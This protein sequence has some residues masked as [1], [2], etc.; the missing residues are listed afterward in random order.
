MGKTANTT[1]NMDITGGKKLKDLFRGDQ[2]LHD[3]F[4]FKLHHQANFAVILIGVAF[5]FGQN[6]LN[7]N[8][9]E[10]KG[11]DVGD[12][13]KQYCWLHGAGHIDDTLNPQDI[14][15]KADQNEMTTEFK[16]DERQSHYYLWIPFVLVL[17]LAVI[18]APRVIWKE[19]CERG[20]IAGAVGGTDGKPAEKIAER[21]KK[22]RRRANKFHRAFFLCE[23]LNIASVIICFTILNTLFGGNFF[24]YGS[25]F[26]AYSGSGSEDTERETVNPMCNLFP[27]VVSCTLLTG[28][29]T[30]NADQTNITGGR[31]L[32]DLYRGDAVLHD[33]FLFKLHH[34]AN[35]AIVLL[36]VAFI[37][38]TNYLDG[39][40]IKC[41]GNN[42]GPFQEQYCWL[43]GSG[44]ITK[45]LNP[46]NIQCIA[47]QNQS[48]DDSDERH[49]RYYLWVPFILMLCLAIIKAPRVLWKEVCERGTTEGVVRGPDGQQQPADKIA[50]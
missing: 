19:V 8:A 12:F 47:N 45:S 48:T 29:A 27:S 38:Y 28:G 26:A 39:K 7:G 33:N 10:C 30:G 36:G 31:K 18:K 6:Y 41:Y 16:S 42:V 23:L 34:Q 22:L 20:M 24:D 2:V 14:K 3:N 5:I 49:T 17:C 32:K 25:K 46:G 11:K 43:H 44:H 1:E 4:L 15:C 50:E 21:F 13:E 37:F 35:F 40:A 9:I